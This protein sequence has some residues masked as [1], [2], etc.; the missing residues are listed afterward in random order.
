MMMALVLQFHVVGQSFGT[1]A[2]EFGAEHVA[3]GSLHQ[4]VHRAAHASGFVGSAMYSACWD[5]AVAE[6]GFSCPLASRA[7]CTSRIGACKVNDL[8]VAGGTGETGIEGG[9]TG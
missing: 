2:A 5:D 1:V 8:G 7:A 4:R 3:I 9:C 6:R